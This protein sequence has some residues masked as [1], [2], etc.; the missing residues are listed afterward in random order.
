MASVVGSSA[1]AAETIDI[2]GALVAFHRANSTA[3][4]GEFFVL[5]GDGSGGGQWLA[6]GLTV[7]V[8]A[9]TGITPAWT[10][11][12]LHQNYI[13]HSWNLWVNNQLVALNCGCHTAATAGSTTYVAWNGISQAIHIDDLYLTKTDDSRIGSPTSPGGATIT[14][15]TSG[16]GLTADDEARWGRGGSCGRD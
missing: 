7:A 4:T 15:G 1:A 10:R 11:L 12:T 8:D 9:T 16:N 14:E 3:T 13:T 6:T 5:D 2:D